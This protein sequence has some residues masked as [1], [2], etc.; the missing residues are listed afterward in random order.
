MWE[1]IVMFFFHLYHSAAEVM[2]T[3][4]LSMQEKG[5][6][7]ET[8]FPED[9]PESLNKAEELQRL[10]NSIGR[11]LNTFHTD[12]DCQLIG[13]GTFAG[14]RKCLPHGSR[15]DVFWEYCAFAES[16]GMQAASYNTFMK[17]A[18]SIMKPGLRD[19]HLRFRKPGEHAQCDFC[20]QARERIREAR[21]ADAKLAEE[22][23]LA[24]HR[25]S[26]WQDRQ[27]YWSFRSMSQ[28]FFSDLLAAN[29]ALG[30]APN[31]TT[32]CVIVDGMD[33]AK[34]R[35]PR[36]RKKTSK[37]LSTMRRPC[38]RASA[39]WAHGFALNLAI[40]DEDLKKDSESVA[41]QV[42]RTLDNILLQKNALPAGC[43]LQADNTYRECKNQFMAA[44]GAL[45]IVL[46]IFRFWSASFLRKGHSP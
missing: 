5:A 17:V 6:E 22:R 32:L 43:N 37:L 2:P 15:T 12:I 41:E 31:V 4:W 20:F 25:L 28:T 21:S 39:C 46:G 40:S 36:S 14:P 35:T 13:P 19:G 26:Q 38:L 42:A 29:G 9:S 10:V 24:R 3:N 18:N 33:Q 1:E 16:R 30:S 23:E 34:F 8:P 27:I 11:T 45:T 7:I 44:F